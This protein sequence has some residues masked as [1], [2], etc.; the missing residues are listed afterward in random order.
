M[1]YILI[2]SA[3][4]LFDACASQKN[5]T[6]YWINSYTVDCV[7]SGPQKCLLVQKNIAISDTAWHTFYA[8]IE[9]F[10]FEPGYLYKI[11]VEEEK[12]DANKVPADASSIKYKLVKIIEKDLD[13]K[14]HIND[15]WV[16]TSLNGNKITPVS[17]NERRRNVQIE[18]Q[19]AERK[20]MGT[21]GCNRFTG[22]IKAIGEET[23]LL[24]TL[25]STRMMCPDM[26]LSV[27]F[28]KT[29]QEVQKY[30][31][32]NLQLTLFDK[33][34]KELMTFKKVD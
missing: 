28:N 19:L 27:D 29:I 10:D 4:I 32:E 6:V 7:G 12:L 9:G 16:L 11:S 1:K 14:L 33:D 2:V 34:S 25:A 15:I 5:S 17:T 31:I 3:L 18:F 20:V 8:P 13:P 23:L 30:A 21:D 26:T 24:G 22:S